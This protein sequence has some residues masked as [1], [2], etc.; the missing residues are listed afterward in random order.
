MR[1]YFLPIRFGKVHK[2]FSLKKDAKDASHIP[3]QKTKMY[4]SGS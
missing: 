1:E 2:I 3:A 4:L